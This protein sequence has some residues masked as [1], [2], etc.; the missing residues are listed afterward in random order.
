MKTT[1]KTYFQK[2]LFIFALAGVTFLQSC[3]EDE[4]LC[5]TG[6]GVVNEYDISITQFDK[7]SIS[8]PVNLRIKQGS[9]QKVTVFAEPELMQPIR[10]KVVSGELEIGYDNNITCFNTNFGV[11]IVITVPDINEIQASGENIIESDGDLDLDNLFINAEGKSTMNLKGKVNSQT[12][13]SSGQTVVNN[14]NLLTQSTTL[15]I[16]GEGNLEVSCEE[17]L[18]IDVD[19][20]STISYKGNPSITQKVSGTLN[21]IDAN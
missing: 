5:L 17:E 9:V 16:S 20:V 18:D 3:I 4:N 6:S 2:A 7:I 21:L 8:G 11:W 1:I 19:G 13:F 10:Y 15:D 12:I 14:F